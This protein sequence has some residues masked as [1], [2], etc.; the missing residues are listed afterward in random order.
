MK[1]LSDYKGAAEL[2][3]AISNEKKI[4][5]MS[6]LDEGRSN[7]EIMDA[8]EMDVYKRQALQQY[9]ATLRQSGML[10]KTGKKYKL[11]KKGKVALEAAEILRETHEDLKNRQRDKIGKLFEDNKAGFSGNMEELKEILRE[12]E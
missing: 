2:A 1:K 8:C 4:V 9:L 11:S 5:I 6:G 7:S 10:L 3:K 12:L